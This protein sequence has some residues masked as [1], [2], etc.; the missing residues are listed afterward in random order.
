MFR[1]RVSK[2][3]DLVPRKGSTMALTNDDELLVLID[4]REIPETWGDLAALVMQLSGCPPSD[5]AYAVTLERIFH[6][7][8]VLLDDILHQD[9]LQNFQRDPIPELRG[10]RAAAEISHVEDE[11]DREMI[12]FVSMFGRPG[13]IQRLVSSP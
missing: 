10:F 3:Q 5:K 11:F 9:L 13:T 4:R 2:P 1:R 6:L 8:P 7:M 12:K